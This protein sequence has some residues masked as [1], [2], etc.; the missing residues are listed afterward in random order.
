MTYSDEGQ[1]MIVPWVTECRR[2]GVLAAR[3][4]RSTCLI[5]GRRAERGR[6]RLCQGDLFRRE[7]A[8]DALRA[9]GLLGGQVAIDAMVE[10]LGAAGGG[11]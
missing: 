1:G 6:L 9:A 10:S 5:S 11:S 7:D 4:V 3:G 8:E 2:C